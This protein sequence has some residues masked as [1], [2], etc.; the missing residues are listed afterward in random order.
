[1]SE[2]REQTTVQPAAPPRATSRAEVGLLDPARPSL[3]SRLR[4]GV[5][6]P[7]VVAFLLAAALWQ[8][9]AGNHPYVIP[10][11]SDIWD[12]L[13][14]NTGMYWS[15]FKTTLQ[16][17]AIGAAGGILAAFLLAVLMA[18]LPIFERALMPLMV[19]LMVTPVVAIAPALV[20]A[21]G[22]G[23]MPK[24][25]VTGLV[26]FFPMLVNSLAG[27]RDVDAKTL[28]VLTTL[29]ASRWETFR[30]L[31]FPGSLPFVFTGLRIALPL[32][33]VGATVAEFAAAGQEAGLGGLITVASSQANLPI[34]WTSIFLL[35]VLGVGLVMVL[36][37]VRR[38]VLWW[39]NEAALSSR[40]GAGAVSMPRH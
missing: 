38:R 39:D 27:L 20:I 40:A 21:F 19:T 36:A 17:V 35:C 8:W 34:I 15:N 1:M 30:H 31:R 12:S 6:L 22:F 28:D 13:S 7:P 23:S 26:V 33:V 3:A 10:T 11:I 29:H 37:I 4:L 32:A 14:Q 2:V 25:T 18:E 24:Y 9:Y 5:W 16:E